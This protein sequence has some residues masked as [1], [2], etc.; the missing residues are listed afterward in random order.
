ME[1]FKKELFKSRY[2]VPF[3]D[4]HSLSAEEREQILTLLKRRLGATSDGDIMTVL[5]KLDEHQKVVNG[6]SA[7]S[8]EFDL[9]QVIPVPVPV[10][11][12]VLVNWY[13]FDDVDAVKFETLT[14]YFGDIWYPASDDIDIFD[15]RVSWVVSVRHD[16]TVKG[17]Q[18]PN[19]P[20]RL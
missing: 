2:G 11:Q 4:I 5:H 8:D 12:V 7:D 1:H 19:A 18:F 10:D 6:A 16:G 13:R 14:K 17:T 20:M 15:S 9:A 3:P